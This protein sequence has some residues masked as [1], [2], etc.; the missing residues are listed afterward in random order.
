[1]LRLDQNAALVLLSGGQDSGTCLAWALSRFDRVETIGFSYGQRHA[2]E[3][4]ARLDVRKALADRGG[5]RATLGSDHMIELGALSAM[6]DT[7]MTADIAFETSSA[8]LPN[9]FVPGR[10]LAFLVMAGALAYR[11]DL[12]V[13]VGGMCGTDAAGYPDCRA[14]AIG[15]Q[16]AALRE[17][18][19]AD[20]T[21]ETPLMTLSKGQTWALAERIGGADLVEMLRLRTHT[22]Y[23]GKRGTLYDWGHGCADCPACC[24]R[25]RGWAAY[26]A[27]QS[28]APA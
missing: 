5:W 10:N 14:A 1:M 22:C 18:M 23:R 24:E 8:G 28:D 2:A 15:A 26:Q 4:D 3:L 21:V 27:S 19:N 9:T 12:G 6:G 7:A 20:L 11:R 16:E 17:G 25:A 13:L